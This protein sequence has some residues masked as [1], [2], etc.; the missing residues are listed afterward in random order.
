VREFD[1]VAFRRLFSV[2]FQ[3]FAK[4]AAT[5]SENIW[6]GDVER[7]LDPARIVDAAERAGAAPFLTALPKG[8]NTPLS[9]VFDDGRELSIGQW[10]RVALARAFLPDTRYI[11]MDEPTSAVDP[12]AEM[13]LFDTLRERIGDRGA[14]IISHRLSTIRHVDYI[15]VLES[16]RIVEEGSHESLLKQE[17]RYAALFG[18]QAAYFK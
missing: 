3:D 4:Y 14:L 10:Q 11:I 8:Y 9:R 16:G 12:R 7:P 18:R 1:P 5:V 17:G 6:Y 2:I 15:Y 13:E